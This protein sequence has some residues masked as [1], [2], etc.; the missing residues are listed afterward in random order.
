ML[1]FT[2]RRD[3]FLNNWATTTFS[4]WTLL[5]SITVQIFSQISEGLEGLNFHVVYNVK[6]IPGHN[7]GSDLRVSCWPP[8]PAAINT[9]FI[10]SSEDEWISTE[11][12][13][14]I[15]IYSTTCRPTSWLK[16]YVFF[17][18]LYNAI[19][20]PTIFTFKRVFHFRLFL[21]TV[22]PA[23]VI[24]NPTELN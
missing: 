24:L 19:K 21:L 4:T 17:L 8:L 6:L 2:K 20:Q 1:T 7:H 23:G 15:N 13:G 18:H 22:A 11:E 16:G 9:S 10:V 14:A 5:H 12:D 3:N